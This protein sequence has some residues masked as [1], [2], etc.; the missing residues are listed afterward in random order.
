MKL[1]TT[2][3]FLAAGLTVAFALSPLSTQAQPAGARG[4]NFI[5]IMQPGDSISS[6]AERFTSKPS[7]WRKIK[8]FNKISQ[9]KL[10]P[11]GKEILVPFSLIDTFPDTAKITSLVGDVTVN[12]QVADKNTV[13]AESSRIQTGHNSTVTFKLSNDNVIAIA[14]DS[15]VYIQRLRQFAGTALIDAIF[16]TEQGEFSAK[17]ESNNGGIGRFEI[18]TPVSI[19]GVRGTSLR[20]RVD[21]DGNTVIELL[22]GKAAVANA[23]SKNAKENALPANQGAIISSSGKIIQAML[24]EPP[25]YTTQLEPNALIVNLP[26]NPDAQAHIIRYT[27]DER[28]L[29]ELARYHSTESKATLPLPSVSSFYLQVR[30]VNQDGLSGIDTAQYIVV[31][32]SSEADSVAGAKT[33]QAVSKK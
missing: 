14:P 11:V 10:V 33:P 32:T 1:F 2:K 12:N 5:Y 23:N 30:A 3:H 15:I 27:A 7:N 18:R 13:I 24:P 29:I 9:D 21:A 20:S 28:G 22:S 6:V 19:T 17:V 31:P 25:Q 8:S 16:K 26:N 4:D